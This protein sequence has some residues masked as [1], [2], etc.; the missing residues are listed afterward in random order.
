MSTLFRA[1][2]FII[3][4]T[5]NNPNVNR[6]QWKSRFWNQMEHFLVIKRNDLAS[7]I[8]ETPP[9]TKKKKKRN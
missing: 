8:L 3:A 7:S 9:P 2:L 4:Q 5:G 6:S 1:V